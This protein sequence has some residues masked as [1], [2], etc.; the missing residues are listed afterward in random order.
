[1]SVDYMALPVDLLLVLGVLVLEPPR[2]GPLEGDLGVAG[3][4]VVGRMVKRTEHCSS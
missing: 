4:M 3:L 1:M 2:D